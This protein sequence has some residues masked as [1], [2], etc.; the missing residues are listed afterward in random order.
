[1]E[2][3][4]SGFA[5][6]DVR[7]P[8]LTVSFDQIDKT[9]MLL[10]PLDLL[11]RMFKEHPDQEPVDNHVTDDQDLLSPMVPKDFLLEGL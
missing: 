10:H 4:F 3:T 9:V 11:Q 2:K 6:D 7:E 1:M 8:G 5:V